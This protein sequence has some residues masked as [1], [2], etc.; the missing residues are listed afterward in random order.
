MRCMPTGRWNFL[1][2]GLPGAYYR[3]FKYHESGWLVLAA[4]IFWVIFKKLGRITFSPIIWYA[5]SS[6]YSDLHRKVKKIFPAVAYF[7][8]F[9]Q[10][11]VERP[12]MV[13]W[14]MSVEQQLQGLPCLPYAC[15]LS[16]K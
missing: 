8:H 2:R 16:W 14:A 9:G 13:F 3:K 4:P 1:L 12:A 11:K 15:S 7:W 5:G 6:I 10:K